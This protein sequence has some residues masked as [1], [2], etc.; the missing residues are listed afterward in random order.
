MDYAGVKSEWG[1]VSRQVTNNISLDRSAATA[2]FNR[3]RREAEQRVQQAERLKM[4]AEASGNPGAIIA[5]NIALGIAKLNLQITLTRIQA[6]QANLDAAV[7]ALEASRDALGSIFIDTKLSKGQE[8][9]ATFQKKQS[10]WE[11]ISRE[12]DALLQEVK[13]KGEPASWMSTEASENYS[14]AVR[15]QMA[16]LQDLSISADHNAIASKGVAD[17]QRSMY[18]AAKNGLRTAK[19]YLVSYQPAPSTGE[20]YGLSVQ[21]SQSQ[22]NKL[23]SWS[24][25]FFTHYDFPAFQ[26]EN[27]YRAAVTAAGN[28]RDG[29][30][31]RTSHKVNESENGDLTTNISIANAEGAASRVSRGAGLGYNF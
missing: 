18:V 6:A 8:T 2:L 27:T 28:T 11:G 30:P 21:K 25:T 19:A 23:K 7:S 31:Q 3:K 29:W 16:A 26:V 20:I 9:V 14:E 5:A 22:V 15:P 10:E 24:R 13:A 12:A 17:V 4:A 1:M